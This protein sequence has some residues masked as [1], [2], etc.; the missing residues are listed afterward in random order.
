MTDHPTAAVSPTSTFDEMK[1]YL[2]EVHARFVITTTDFPEDQRH[3]DQFAAANAGTLRKMLGIRSF[4]VYQ[5]E[6]P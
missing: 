3:W 6:Q 1:S 5:V 2:N 4:V